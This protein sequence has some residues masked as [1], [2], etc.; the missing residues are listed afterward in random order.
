MRVTEVEREPSCVRVKLD[1]GE[2]MFR[3][4]ED[5]II[6]CVYNVDTKQE[7]GGEA[8]P[9]GIPE[10]CGGALEVQ[11]RDRTLELSAGRL[12]VLV[13]QE[14]GTFRWKDEKG[15]LLLEEGKKELQ[16]IRI[17]DYAIVDGEARS[18]LVRTVDGD[19]N[20]T[21]NLLPVSSHTGFRGKLRFHLKEKERIHGLG[22]GEEGIY[23]YRGNTQYLYQHNMR[24]PV[25]FFVSDQG[26]GILAD[27]G[28]LMVWNDDARGSYL[29]LDAVS[30]LDYYLIA[31]ESLD[32]II[33][34]FR[35]LTGKAAL[36]PRWAYGYLQSRETYC[37]Q[38]ELV[39]AVDEY[40]RRNIPLD[41]IVQDWHT[42]KEGGWGE[43]R[44][45][46]ERY[47]DF[48]KAVDEIH[49]KNAHVIFSVWP[50]AGIGT[51]DNREFLEKGELLNDLSTYDAFSEKARETYWGQLGRELYPAGVDGWWCDSTEPFSGADWNGRYHRE[52]WERYELVGGEHKKYL[53]AERANLYALAHA[54]GIFE[55]QRKESDEKRVFN[56]TRSGYA[57]SQKYGTVLWSGDISATWETLRRQIREGLNMCMSGIPF[58][59]MDA[60]AFFVVRDH[61]W[62]RGAF[63]DQISDLWWYWQGD[64]EDGVEDMAYRELYVR[65]LEYAAFVPVFR[66]HGT[67]TP[68]EIWNFGREGEPFYDA[69]AKTIRLRY[70]LMPYIYSMA[71]KV[72]CRDY[73]MMRSLLFDFPEDER[74][75]D[76]ET[77]YMFGE[78]ILVCPVT[79]PM[80]FD[81]GSRRI[82]R[83]Q[84]RECYLPGGTDWYDFAT[85]ERHTGGSTVTAQ[86]PLE[87]IPLF[88]RAGAIL[89]MEEGLTYAGEQTG[90]PLEIHIYPGADGSFLYYE[91]A[92]DGYG[93]EKGEYQLIEFRWEDFTGR[94]TIGAAERAFPG[95]IVGRQLCIR[96][97]GQDEGESRREENV[98]YEGKEIGVV[99][100]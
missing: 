11:E 4:I 68:R 40:R 48:K 100:G 63:A 71:G 62:K 96:L 30:C 84:S 25:P 41:G 88:V 90:N 67:D 15:R 3:K 14:T 5:N 2:L 58:W 75:K 54:R 97:E 87:R 70:R 99:F 65:W 12:R 73:T 61:W 9:L 76:E 26:Y 34:G 42:W 35:R 60:G 66:S 49:E 27:C 92:G 39:A 37:T 31:G 43:K 21:E 36:L 77:E 6:R 16:E 23:N 33:A 45:D 29:L 38:Q 32:E 91:D 28:S 74:A 72:Y 79:E 52:P 78:S 93:Y 20:F 18:R 59:T 7:T 56:L 17:P 98:R 95:G 64:Y 57:G 13:D 44:L 51:D 80:Y 19:R 1:E 55:N 24:T 86:A 8:S 47:P 89:P 53:K 50:N 83:A 81:R 94:L 82:Q 22:Q 10:C 46:K 85:G 69:I